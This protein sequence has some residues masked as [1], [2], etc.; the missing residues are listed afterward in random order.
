VVGGGGI[1]LAGDGKAVDHRLYPECCRCTQRDYINEEEEEET[2][3][4]KQKQKQKKQK[5]AQHP[6][7]RKEA[8]RKRK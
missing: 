1:V 3:T 2:T 7:G 4:K 5:Y 6:M 8:E